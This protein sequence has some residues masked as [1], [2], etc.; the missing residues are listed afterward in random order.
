MQANKQEANERGFNR[1]RRN[2]VNLVYYVTDPC[3]RESCAHAAHVS[4]TVITFY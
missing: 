3:V 2:Y 4:T 1:N